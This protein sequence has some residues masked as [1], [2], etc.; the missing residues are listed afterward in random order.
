MAETLATTKHHIQTTHP[1]LSDLE[2]LRLTDWLTDSAVEEETRVI[3]FY[4]TYSKVD[5][6]DP[7]GGALI[8]NYGL[9]LHGRLS[10]LEIRINTARKESQSL[11]NMFKSGL[12]KFV[13][14]LST[15]YCSRIG[16][17]CRCRSRHILQRFA[18][19]QSL[20]FKWC[21]PTSMSKSGHRFC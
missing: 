20:A 2:V 7:L 6:D 13:P 17:A 10:F 4:P 16:S 14:F 5:E 1:F 9:S 11:L 8:T 21:S 18:C 19:R 12:A 3:Q 15:L